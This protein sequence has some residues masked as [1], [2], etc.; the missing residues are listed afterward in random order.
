MHASVICTPPVDLRRQ[1]DDLQILLLPALGAFS[2]CVGHAW[3][4]SWSP[5]KM[6]HRHRLQTQIHQLEPTSQVKYRFQ[7]NRRSSHSGQNS[8][9][10]IHANEFKTMAINHSLPKKTQ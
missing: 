3:N 2:D 7:I 4:E 6:P 10:P 5:L 1:V 9:L 8:E